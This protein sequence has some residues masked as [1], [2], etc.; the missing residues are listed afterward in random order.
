MGKTIQKDEEYT[1]TYTY[2]V[3]S[4]AV[5]DL[6]L[7]PGLC[8]LTCAQRLLHRG[9]DGG[10]ESAVPGQA[11]SEDVA[12]DPATL[13]PHRLSQFLVAGKI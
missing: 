13:E 9:L 12:L 11:V 10:E 3:Q 7:D 5:A 6:S 8:Q 2:H 4:V 1:C